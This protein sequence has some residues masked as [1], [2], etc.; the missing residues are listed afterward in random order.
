VLPVGS[1]RGAPQIG[2]GQED[3]LF[4]ADAC[5]RS[6]ISQNL[7]IA[8]LP[9]AANADFTLSLSPQIPGIQLSQTTGKTPATV[10]ISVDPTAFQAAKGTTTVTLNIQSTA[11]INIPFPVRL[12]INTRDVNQTGRIV[13]VPGK[14][15]DI[16][17]DRTRNRI[18]MVRQDKNLVL[19]YDS[20]TFQQL[21]ALRTA[22]TPMGMAITADQNYLIVG[23]DN[24]QLASV[25]DLNALQAVDPIFTPGVYPHLFAV[26]NGSI[27]GTERS[28]GSASQSLLSV[29]FANRIATAPSTLGIYQNN[30][31]AN[32]A[33]AASP[34]GNYILL[35]ETNGTVAMWDDTVNLLGELASGSYQPR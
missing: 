22:N 16:L 24:S 35:A 25:F 1:L 8:A 19:V 32:S 20:R 11:A 5:N 34:S 33:L 9:G 6:V 12:L 7:S 30:V 3:V 23:N 28:V 29:D 31:P 13:D 27:W 18:Y 15:V 26:G 2:A 14:I 4:L 21:A 17:A 10:Q